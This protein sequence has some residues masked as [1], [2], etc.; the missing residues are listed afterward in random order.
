MKLVSN[1]RDA[2]R[3]LSVRAMALAGALQG[4]W[5]AMSPD[6]QAR[7]PAE[8]VDGLTMAILVLG[9]FGRI[10]DQGSTNDGH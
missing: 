1:W 6:L 3:W 5:L 9:I 10:V 2:P 8:W 7:V 4:A